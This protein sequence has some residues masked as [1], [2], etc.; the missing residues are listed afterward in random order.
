MTRSTIQGLPITCAPLAATQQSM[1]GHVAC[2]DPNMCFGTW[3]LQQRVTGDD[4][5]AFRSQPLGADTQGCRDSGV[6]LVFRL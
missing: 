6:A 4:N 3:A 2:V 5:S 1:S